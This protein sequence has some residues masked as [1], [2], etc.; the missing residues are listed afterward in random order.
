MAVFFGWN[1]VEPAQWFET[2]RLGLHLAW[3]I[4]VYLAFQL[5][6]I[7]FALRASRERFIGVV[8]GFRVCA[9]RRPPQ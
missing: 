7:P 2:N 1:G 9:L 8:D 3:V 6:S 5:V 4:F